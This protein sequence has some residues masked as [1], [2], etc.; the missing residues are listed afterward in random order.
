MWLEPRILTC[1]SSACRCSAVNSLVCWKGFRLRAKLYILKYYKNLRE[2]LRKVS[3]GLLPVQVGQFG[4]V[5]CRGWVAHPLHPYEWV[6]Q[7]INF[8]KVEA[9][10]FTW[11]NKAKHCWVMSTNFLFSKVC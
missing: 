5:N 7:S 6:C 9:G 3:F 1:V 8:S 2:G 10:K 4:H 11:G